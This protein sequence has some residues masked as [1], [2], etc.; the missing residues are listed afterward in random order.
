[1]PLLMGLE[2]RCAR[3]SDCG[4]VSL[5]VPLRSVREVVVVWIVVA[6]VVLVVLLGAWLVDRHWN[7]D[8]R[9]MHAPGQG[10]SSSDQ[11][12]TATRD[13]SGGSL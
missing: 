1:V 2:R 5:P 13:H 11:A 4:T 6:L 7:V 9:G 8:P 3:A 12:W 10:Q